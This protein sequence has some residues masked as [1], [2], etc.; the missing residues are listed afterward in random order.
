MFLRLAT[1]HAVCVV[2]F[3]CFVFAGRLHVITLQTLFN[4]ASPRAAYTSE[5]NIWAFIDLERD[6]IIT[7]LWS[8]DSVLI[9]TSCFDLFS[10]L[11][12][13]H[14]HSLYGLWKLLFCVGFR[15]ILRNIIKHVLVAA[16]DEICNVL[17]LHTCVAHLWNVVWPWLKYGLWKVIVFVGLRSIPRIIIKHVLAAARDEICKVLD[18][19]TFS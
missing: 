17:D 1:L 12:V 2:F 19:H 18:L 9:A 15:S 7:I 6:F 10:P 3:W 5:K 11:Y 14:L 16:R 8:R 13:W 4:E